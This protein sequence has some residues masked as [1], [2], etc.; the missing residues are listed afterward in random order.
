M[1]IDAEALRHHA[2]DV[3]AERL[4]RSR[5]S[6]RRLDEAERLA[7]EE[8]ALA[9]GQAVAGYLLERAAADESLANVLAG[10]YPDGN[11]SSRG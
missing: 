2:A 9:V 8:T 11:S 7:V 5:G 1:S 3:S 4:S 6:L 10:L